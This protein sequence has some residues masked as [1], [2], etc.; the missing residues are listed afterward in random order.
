MAPRKKIPASDTKDK[1]V[2]GPIKAGVQKST[3]KTATKTNAVRDQA[4]EEAAVSSTPV[5]V[6]RFK[7]GL[8]NLTK[9]PDH[10]LAK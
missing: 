1:G 9:M 3:K 2:L 5:R 6:K 10:L 7:N 8:V 4:I